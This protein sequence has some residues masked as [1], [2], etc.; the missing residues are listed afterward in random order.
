M[1]FS[2]V[3]FFMGGGKRLMKNIVL[4]GPVYPYKGGI[5]YYTN[6]LY[7]ALAKKYKVEM[8]SYKM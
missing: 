3:G 5:A 8:I 6:L 1:K 4:I 7:Q 2:Y